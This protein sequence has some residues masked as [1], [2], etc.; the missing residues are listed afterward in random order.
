MKRI[1]LLLPSSNTTM[2]P[3]FYAMAPAGF[4]VHSA[5][6]MLSDVTPESLE[7]MAGDAMKAAELL[8][9]AEIDVLV[10]GCTSGSL[11]K[12]VEW[13][14]NLVKR[15]SNVSG[16]PTITTAGA[17]VDALRALTASKISVFTPYID[18]INQL[19]KTFLEA[20]GFQVN[21][22]KGLGLVDNQAIG[23]VTH[24]E[25]ERFI[26]PYPGAD[27]VFVSCT[28]LPVIPLIQ[29]LESKYGVPFVT[30]NQ[31]SMWATLKS[32]KHGH[33]DGYGILLREH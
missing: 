3:D 21:S 24:G 28:N 2:E 27:C 14:A 30:S 19:E 4:S 20:H 1:G 7:S 15:L 9:T 11:I 29:D 17:V 22:I 8:K 18:K 26:D 25:L 16:V 6:M 31:A 33:M 23:R 5:R 12:G 10:Y 32:L 13:E